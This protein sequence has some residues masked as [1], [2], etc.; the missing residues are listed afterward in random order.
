MTAGWSIIPKVIG[1]KFANALAKGHKVKLPNSSG[2]LSLLTESQT[3]YECNGPILAIYPTKKLLDKIDGLFDV[4]HVLVIPWIFEDIKQWVETWS[5]HELGSEAPEPTR[6]AKLNPVVIEALK[7]LT[8]TVNLSTGIHHPS[9]KAAAIDLFQRLKNSR[10]DF[11]PSKVRMWLVSEGNWDPTLADD[12]MKVAQAVYEGR[13]V[14][15][16]K[17]IWAEDIIEQWRK[18]ASQDH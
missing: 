9:D 5:A 1:T 14:R 3:I 6:I 18:R 7:T 15:G 4:T 11:G 8:S 2:E 10:E 13:R 17:P 12:V 16:G